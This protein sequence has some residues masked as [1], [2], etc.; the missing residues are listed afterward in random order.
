MTRYEII[1]ILIARRGYK[2]YLE[3]GVDQGDCFNK[4]K[5]EKK[6][7]V[8]PYDGSNRIEDFD[9]ILK[10]HS[11]EDYTEEDKEMLK[12]DLVAE[13]RLGPATHVMTSDLFFE[14][15]TDT[16]DIVFID[17]LHESYQTEGDIMN[18]QVCL[19]SEGVIIVHDCLPLTEEAQRVPRGDV[20]GWNGDAWKAVV[21]LRMFLGINVKTVDTDQGCAII[22]RD[23]GIDCLPQTTIMKWEYFD[24]NRKELMNIITIPEFLRIA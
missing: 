9:A 20:W 19:N 1:N 2:S 3:I 12:K 4:V 11:K 15:N 10:R 24:A 23:H 14:E 21:R 13:Y 16:F 7:G 6:V 5:C 17:G 22:T 18:A 8:D